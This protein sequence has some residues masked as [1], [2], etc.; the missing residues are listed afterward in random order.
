M[1]L[2]WLETNLEIRA[3]GIARHLKNSPRQR[4]SKALVMFWLQTGQ[5]L[6][7]PQKLLPHLFRIFFYLMHWSIQ[8]VK[9]VTNH[10]CKEPIW[11]S[12][13]ERQK[14]KVAESNGMCLV[15]FSCHGYQ[16]VSTH[17]ICL[18]RKRD[19]SMIFRVS[20][21]YSTLPLQKKAKETRKKI[22]I[23]DSKKY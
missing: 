6:L 18:L 21:L 5:L 22:Q 16:T 1:F 7:A 11:I 3:V 15:G 17:V 20:V 14:K 8:N 12:Q 9:G 2:K 19:K 13:S 23:I 4:T 10:E